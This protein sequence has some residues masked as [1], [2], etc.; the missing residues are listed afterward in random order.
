MLVNFTKHFI[1]FLKIIS[2]QIFNEDEVNHYDEYKYDYCYN[3]DILLSCG[4]YLFRLSFPHQHQI[5]VIEANDNLAPIQLNYI[6]G[7][8]TSLVIEKLSDYIQDIFVIN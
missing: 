8:D 2:Y 5:F 6:F 1:A 4:E 3:Y 7:S